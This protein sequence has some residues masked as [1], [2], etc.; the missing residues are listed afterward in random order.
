MV[1]KPTLHIHGTVISTY[2]RIVQTVAE[3]AGVAWQIT[4]TPA[5]SEEN[6]RRHPFQK[7]PTVSIDGLNLFESVAITQYIDNAHN[8]GGLQPSDPKVRAE[9]DRWVAIANNYLFPTFEHGLLMPYLAHQY[10]KTLL[11]SDV[12]EA[13][14]PDIAHHLGVICDRIEQSAHFAGSEFTLADIFIYCITRP[15]QMT[16]E[17]DNL[18]GQLLPLRHWLNKIGQRKSL[19]ATRWPRETEVP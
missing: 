3:E 12:V 11:R 10:L 14:I 2:T 5:Q 16:P 13:A 17:G 4:A 1:S 19:V 8:N 6:K 7:V 15:V 18:I 9:M